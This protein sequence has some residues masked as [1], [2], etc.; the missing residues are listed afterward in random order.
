MKIIKGYPP[1]YAEICKAIGK[2]ESNYMFTY[3]D[4]I[5]FPEGRSLDGRPDI[6]AHEEVHERQQSGWFMSPEKWWRR[7]LKDNT[8]RY[9][10]ELEAYRLQWHYIQRHVRDREMRNKLLNEFARMLSS[11]NYGNV[12]RFNDAMYQIKLNNP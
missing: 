9:K 6:I 1:N 12:V 11:K 10:Q 7:Y 4:T 8:F 2:P 3:G 5:Y